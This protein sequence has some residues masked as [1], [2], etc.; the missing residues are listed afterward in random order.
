MIFEIF[1][2]E[3]CG[4]CLAISHVLQ[5]KIGNP[6]I[7]LD[8][9]YSCWKNILKNFVSNDISS[10]LLKKINYIVAV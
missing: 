5:Y 1:F 7:S 3:S 10:F 2:D 4:I 9:S 8:K 6:I